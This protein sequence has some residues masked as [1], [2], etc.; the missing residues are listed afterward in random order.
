MKAFFEFYDVLLTFVNFKLFH[1]LGSA[2]YPP[3]LTEF[4][5]SR[6]TQPV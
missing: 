6:Q 2:T 3:K 1:E 4:A 5:I